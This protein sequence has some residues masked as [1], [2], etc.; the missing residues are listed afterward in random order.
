MSA[1]CPG[2]DAGRRRAPAPA[3]R[4]QS[5]ASN[6]VRPVERAWRSGQHVAGAGAK[7]AG[8]I[9]APRARLPDR[10][11]CSNRYRARTRRL[12]SESRARETRRRPDW[13]R[14]PGTVRRP[15]RCC[16]RP[17]GLGL[18]SCAW[19]APGT[20]AHRRP[21]DR[22]AIRPAAAPD[23]AMQSS[24][25]LVCSAAWMWTGPPFASGTMAASSSAVTA[26]SECGATP[27]VRIGNVAMA[28]RHS[29]PS[30]SRNAST[31]VHE[32]ALARH[33]RR[34]AEIAMG[35]EH[36]QQA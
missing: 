9:P 31:A 29:L 25:S 4:R 13:L 22:A 5:A 26:R 6:K 15:R 3:P 34:A 33:G 1:G 23:Q 21:H 8:H 32:A 20:S 28:R 27:N 17:Q 2:A 16:A 19:R 12:R 36:R 18:R 30:D 11:G 35:I 10:S 7:A 24:T 14:S